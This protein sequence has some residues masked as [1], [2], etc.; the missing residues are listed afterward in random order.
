M[1]AMRRAAQTALGAFARTAIAPQARGIATQA[2]LRSGAVA[3]VSRGAAVSGW[4]QWGQQ[5]GAARGF[6][7][8]ADD[9][10]AEV[11]ARAAAKSAELVAKKDAEI[12]AIIQEGMP[13]PD[14]WKGHVGP[15][16]PSLRKDKD[17]DDD[18][19]VDMDREDFPNASPRV[20]RIAEG[21]AVV[22][23]FSLTLFFDSVDAT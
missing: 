19:V 16:H 13:S 3:G 4:Q 17:P 10:T 2:A 20:R 18:R 11:R 7:A 6:A 15:N 1:A 14:E 22:A 9:E 23:P 21:R 5:M 8:D 12:Q